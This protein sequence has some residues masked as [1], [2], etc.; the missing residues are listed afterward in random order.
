MNGQLNPRLKNFKNS[1]N[2]SS[3][4]N[5]ILVFHSQLNRSCVVVCIMN[6]AAFR[7]LAT[8]A[9]PFFC[10]TS[11]HHHSLPLKSHLIDDSILINKNRRLTLIG[12]C[13]VSQMIVNWILNY[14]YFDSL[15][16]MITARVYLLD[17]QQL[18]PRMNNTSHPLF[19]NTILLLNGDHA[20]KCN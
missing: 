5:F 7:W 3:L 12:S 17:Q 18:N 8:L 9:L 14:G 10:E 4:H 1:V 15:N 6:R 2:R 16:E 19:S 13:S 11:P 20:Y